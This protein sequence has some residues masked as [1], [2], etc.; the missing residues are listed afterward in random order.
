MVSYQFQFHGLV[1]KFAIWVSLLSDSKLTKQLCKFSKLS[2]TSIHFFLALSLSLPVVNYWPVWPDIHVV[3]FSRKVVG[4][5]VYLFLYKAYF[6]KLGKSVECIIL[7]WKGTETDQLKFIHS[8]CSCSSR[9]CTPWCSTCTSWGAGGSESGSTR[10][11][12]LRRTTKTTR[13]YSRVSRERWLNNVASLE[14]L[15]LKKKLK[16]KPALKRFVQTVLKS[17]ELWQHWES[18]FMHKNLKH[19]PLKNK[20]AWNWCPL[21]LEIFIKPKWLETTDSDLNIW[22]I[23]N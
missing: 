13:T 20:P 21:K 7:T 8:S 3:L 14:Q 23:Q 11:T 22:S 6:K 15:D 5:A 4:V 18:F 10:P 9:C 12:G 1:L 17:C 16:M 19:W 2:P